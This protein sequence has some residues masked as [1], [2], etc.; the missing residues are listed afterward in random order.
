MASV[1]VIESEVFGS[2]V[3]EIVVSV[4]I[5]NRDIWLCCGWKYLRI[6]FGGECGSISSVVVGDG[7]RYRMA[8]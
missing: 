8:F 2:S 7:A 6:I 3:G 1:M 4:E 5:E